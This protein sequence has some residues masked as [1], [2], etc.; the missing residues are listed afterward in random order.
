MH[1]GHGAPNNKHT[2]ALRQADPAVPLGATSSAGFGGAN[3]GEYR[4]SFHGYPPGTAQLISSPHSFVITPMQIDTWNRDLMDGCGDGRL[5]HGPFGPPSL[6][7]PPLCRHAPVRFWPRC[8]LPAHSWH[9]GLVSHSLRRAS[10][11]GMRGDV[12]TVR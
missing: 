7:P 9:C 5:T 12:G 11:R 2:W 10:E 3:G 8:F 4:Q 1:G 6:A